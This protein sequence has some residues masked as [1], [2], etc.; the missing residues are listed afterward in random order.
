MIRADSGRWRF[1][2]PEWLG[3]GVGVGISNLYYTD[4]RTLGDNLQRLSMQIGTDAFS[5]VLKEFWPDIKQRFFQ[6]KSSI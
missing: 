3:N 6:K 2:T 4:S 1:N 5:N